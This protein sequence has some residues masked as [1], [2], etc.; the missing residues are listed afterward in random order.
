MKIYI[1]NQS[2]P[3]QIIV[4]GCDSSSHYLK[5]TQEIL[6]IMIII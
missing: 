4:D 1:I 5:I 2:L 3:V 6:L